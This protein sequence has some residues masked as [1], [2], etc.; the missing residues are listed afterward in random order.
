MVVRQTP[1]KRPE[2]QKLLTV[3]TSTDQ[4]ILLLV[5]KLLNKI[6]KNLKFII[7]KT[8]FIEKFC[9]FFSQKVTLDSKKKHLLNK[10]Q[11]F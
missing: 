3:P 6:N 9:V 5:R 11:Q 8:L 2:R 4:L 10:Q 1:I 7:I